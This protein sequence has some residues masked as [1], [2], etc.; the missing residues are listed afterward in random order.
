M[1]KST[2]FCQRK[3][4]IFFPFLR[5]FFVFLVIRNQIFGNKREDVW[6][7]K[8][9]I[10]TIINCCW[11]TKKK[12]HIYLAF[13]LRELINFN[14][15]WLKII[16]TFVRVLW[17]LESKNNDYCDKNT[18]QMLFIPSNFIHLSCTYKDWFIL[19]SVQKERLKINWKL[20][21]FLY[22]T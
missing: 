20:I 7:I 1:L 13:L 8:S 11:E 15:Q 21:G 17:L 19:A 22:T 16:K 5:I 12:Q 3:S 2:Y 4:F 6:Q 18:K 14:R 10:M 9:W